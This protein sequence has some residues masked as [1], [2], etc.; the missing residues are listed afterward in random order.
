[1][2]FEISCSIFKKNIFFLQFSLFQNSRFFFLSFF[3]FLLAKNTPKL[4]ELFKKRSKLSICPIIFHVS[5]KKNST[6]WRWPFFSDLWHGKSVTYLIDVFQ[7]LV[8][9]Y[10]SLLTIHLLL[11]FLLSNLLDVYGYL[12]CLLEYP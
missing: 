5:L 10:K 12:P 6:F 7:N 3:L 4:Q 2:I 9:T 1:M 8:K 11:F